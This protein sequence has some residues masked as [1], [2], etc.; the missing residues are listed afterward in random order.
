MNCRTARQTLELYRTEESDAAQ[1]DAAVRHVEDCDSCQVAVR[2]QELLDLKIGRMCCDVPVPAGLKDRLLSRLA[3][4]AAAGDSPAA[5][6]ESGI[7]RAALPAVRAARRWGRRRI[8]STA[9]ASATLVA[10]ALGVWFVVRPPAPQINL[11]E[12]VEHVLTDPTAPDQL[13]VFTSFSGSLPLRLPA[14]MDSPKFV[15]PSRQLP[16]HDVAIYFFSLRKVAGRLIVIPRRSVRD[17]LPIATSF[18]GAIAYRRGYR[19]TAW[20]EGEFVYVC[21]LSDGPVDFHP[22]Q[23]AGNPPA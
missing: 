1:R 4:Q 23:P 2:H 20:V 17:G 6:S 3:L 11:D 10:A 9:L 13:P 15:G 8:V 19:T 21:C 18:P 7:E 22:L 12:V 14:T 5:S 16:D